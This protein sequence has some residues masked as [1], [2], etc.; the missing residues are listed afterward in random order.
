M[1]G[2]EDGKGHIVIWLMKE[3]SK[4]CIILICLDLEF[5]FSSM[6]EDL[7]LNKVSIGLV[8]SHLSGAFSLFF[9]MP[10]FPLAYPCLPSL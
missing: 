1:W 4:N 6:L 3:L 2:T 10:S 5:T 9:F 7:N 8:S